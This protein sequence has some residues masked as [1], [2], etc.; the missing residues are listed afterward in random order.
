MSAAAKT[1]GEHARQLARCAETVMMAFGRG[2]DSDLAWG[3]H[4]LANEAADALWNAFDKGDLSDIE[5]AS[6]RYAQLIAISAATSEDVGHDLL[7]AGEALLEATKLMLDA[8]IER[9]M[10]VQP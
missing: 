9:R 3:F 6:C 10:Q 2:V 4:R 7:F 1:P 5:D 8:E